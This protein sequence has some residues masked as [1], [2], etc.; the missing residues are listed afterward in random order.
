MSKIKAFLLSLTVASRIIAAVSTL[1]GLLLILAGASYR[2]MDTVATETSHT[3]HVNATTME[4][5]ARAQVDLGDLRRNE[6]DAFIAIGNPK[7]EAEF[8]IKWAAERESF[9]RDLDSIQQLVDEDSEREQ[10]QA[11]R[12]AFGRYE[13]GFR[14]IQERIKARDLKDTF[15]ANDSMSPYK[16]QANTAEATLT[17]LGEEEFR[18]MAALPAQVEGQ[19]HRTK[20]ANVFLG[21][22]ATGIAIAVALFL[23]R[24]ITRPLTETIT[25]ARQILQG[26]VLITGAEEISQMQSAFEGVRNSLE[27]TRE[28]KEKIEKD[29]KE[30][31][32]NIIDLLQNVADA[33]DGDLTV[34]AKISTGSLGNVAD[35]FNSLMES[36]Q[37]LL[38]QVR[39]Q[40][41]NTTKAV[42]QIQSA[43]SSMALGAS[44]QAR[45]VL[46]A[47]QLVDQMSKEIAKVSSNANTA[48]EASKRTEERAHEGAIAVEE[49]VTGM[50]SLRANVQAG[51]KKMKN[52]GDRSM[53]ITGIVGTISR[54]SEQTNMLA[55]NAA[56][57]AARAGEHG[58]GFSVVADEVRKLA[59]RTASAT[60]EIDKLVKAIHV[61]TT[62]TVSAIEQQ[63]TIVEQES[64][65]VG[66]AGESLQKIRQVS[67]ES[68]NI[69]VDISSVAKKQT[70][71]TGQVVKAMEQISAI[72]KATQASVEGTTATVTRLATLSNEL[73]SSVGKF[74]VA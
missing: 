22:S 69:V 58:R 11:I 64:R 59:E 12:T 65:A 17:A 61:E 7:A 57:E 3:L 73:R 46:A 72:A 16:D 52:L 6:K 5:V 43:S 70:E 40:I 48:A 51:A 32:D 1:T 53:E 63:T 13:A 28:L 54:I 67:T 50:G 34:R 21:L 30:L 36:L 35:A 33:S 71:G 45:E 68:A 55:L 4:H 66:K 49:V 56:I 18:I 8:N 9:M 23:T 44:D 10:L 62:E 24:S 27:E 15:T 26:K 31:Q 29:N 14:E 60:Q 39:S 42:D 19:A 25:K 74:K 20:L 47:R 41:D 38:G 2:G 37:T